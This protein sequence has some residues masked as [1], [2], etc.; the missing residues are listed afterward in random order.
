MRRILNNRLLALWMVPFALL[1]F[2]LFRMARFALAKLMERTFRGATYNPGWRPIS[3]R[4]FQLKWYLP[5]MTT[6]GPRWNPHALIA[7]AG[8]FRVKKK[9]RIRVA[10]AY[11]SAQDWTGILY[12]HPH[13]KTVGVVGPAAEGKHTEWVEIDVE[14]GM[15]TF[16]LRYYRLQPSILAP[17]IEIDGAP[18]CDAQALRADT[19]DFYKTIAANSNA[20]YRAMQFYIYALLRFEGWVSPA[21]LRRE[22]LPVGNPNTQ[23]LYGYFQPGQQIHVEI[24][25][26]IFAR[27]YTYLTVYE[28]GSFPVKW[29]DFDLPKL[30]TDVQPRA[31]FYLVRLCAKPGE[32]LPPINETASTRV[33]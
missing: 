24:S 29:W 15:Y 11:A 32:T 14:P 26:N 12:A 5:W 13:Y 25:P 21:F 10:D 8:P 27:S 20:F 7:N 9:I 22:F 3:A 19:N 6:R 17:A 23:F 33:I 31:G 1:S 4:A 16:S 18:F 2:V 30:T 28:R